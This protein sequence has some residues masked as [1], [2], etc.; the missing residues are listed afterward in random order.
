MSTAVKY[1][2]RDKLTNRGVWSNGRGVYSL[3]NRSGCKIPAC[4]YADEVDQFAAQLGRIM[5]RLG[6]ECVIDMVPI[7]VRTIA[8]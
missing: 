8:I 4:L 5:Q 2:V 7:V 6:R 1:R 3:S